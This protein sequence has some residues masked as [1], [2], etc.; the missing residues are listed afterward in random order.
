MAAALHVCWP[1]PQWESPEQSMLLL[2]P[3]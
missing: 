2:Q 1:G 3:Q